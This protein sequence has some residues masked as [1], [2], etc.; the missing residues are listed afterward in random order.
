MKTEERIAWLESRRNGIGSSDAPAILGLSK[1]KTALDVYLAKINPVPS[2]G[3]M[4]TGPQEWG[5]R[6]EPAI[7]GAIMDHTGWKLEKVPTLA[8]REHQFLIASP[9]RVNQDGELIEI[10]TSMRSEGWGEPETADI[11]QAYWI[12]CQHQLE[13]ADRDVCHVFVLIGGNDFRRYRV[14]R[15]AE[16]MPT[17]LI[18]LATFWQKVE[19][20]IPPEPDWSHESTLSAVNRLF[21]PKPGTFKVL[22]HSAELI[23]DEYQRLGA[24]KADCEAKQKELKARLVVELGDYAEGLLTDGRRVTRK[25]IDKKGYEVKP[26]SYIDVRILNPKGEK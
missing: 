21:E 14:E 11:P 10:K 4:M 6:M 8:H 19:E 25:R 12:Q 23:A 20:R 2:D 24:E 5:H 15:D 17:V 9:D 22:D 18:P 3:G 13:V 7:A 16:Y 1:W 26:S